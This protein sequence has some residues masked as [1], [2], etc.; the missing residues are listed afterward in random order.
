MDLHW[1][2]E[3]LLGLV[4][5]FGGIFVKGLND[6]IKSLY[7][8]DEKL[9]EKIHSID[10]LVVGE[11]L[12]R[13]EFKDDFKVLSESLVKQLDRIEGKLDGKADKQRSGS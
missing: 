13:E 11:Y 9:T 12:K 4:A 10:T 8:Q 2:V 7:R 1:I 5:F 6:S 3:I